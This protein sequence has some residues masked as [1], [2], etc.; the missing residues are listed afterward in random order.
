MELR[1]LLDARE[2]NLLVGLVKGLVK[3]LVE[4]LVVGQ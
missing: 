2:H 1:Q 3:G 4:G